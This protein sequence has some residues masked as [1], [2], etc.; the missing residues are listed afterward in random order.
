MTLFGNV[1]GSTVWLKWYHTGLGW[2]GPKANTLT[3]LQ[4][5]ETERH[6]GGG[7]LAVETK[8]KMGLMAG[9][10]I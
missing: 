6:R 5:L 10:K 7:H 1:S 9:T 3:D 2:A 8:I 4:I